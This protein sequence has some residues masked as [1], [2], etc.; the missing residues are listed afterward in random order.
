MKSLIIFIPQNFLKEEP[1]CMYGNVVHDA[2]EEVSKFF[3]LGLTESVQSITKAGNDLVP[4]GY[5]YGTEKKREYWEKKLPNWIELYLSPTDTNYDYYLRT[6]MIRNQKLTSLNSH[7]VIILYDEYCL[8]R[9]ELYI[10]RIPMDHFSELRNILYKESK[11]KNQDK[12]KNSSLPR[13]KETIFT[14]FILTILYPTL[15][16][17]KLITIFNP[18]LKYSSL[19]L[20]L[21]ACFQN[22]KWMASTL[23]QSKK[24]TLKTTNYIL[25]IIID[26]FLGHLLLEVLLNFLENSLPSDVLLSYAEKMV[27]TLKDLVNWLMGSPAGLKLNSSFNRVLGK[28]FLY[29]IHLWWTFLVASKPIMD[30]AF[31]VL[32]FFGRLGITFQISI[33]ADLLALVSFHTYCIY[34]YAARL[35]N[36]QTRGLTALFRLFLGKKKNPLRKRVDSCRYKPDQLFVGTL[37]FTILLFLMPTTWVY[38]FVFTVLRLIMIGLGGF[39]TRLKFYLQVIPIY[40]FILWILRT[41]DTTGSI[42]I[43]LLHRQGE[44]PIM[45]KTKTIIAPWSETW[46]RTLPDTI[47]MHTSINWSNI[48]SN[49]FWGQL[50]N[51]RRTGNISFLCVAFLVN[52]KLADRKYNVRHIFEVMTAKVQEINTKNKKEKLKV[53]DQEKNEKFIESNK[54]SK[55][56]KTKKE[57]KITSQDIKEESLKEILEDTENKKAEKR[58]SEGDE[59]TSKKKRKLK[60]RKS[61]IESDTNNTEELN[62]DNTAMEME[63]ENEEEKPNKEPSKR[64]IKKEKFALR[65]AAIKELGKQQNASKALNYVSKWK[66]AKSEWKFNTVIQTWLIHNLLDENYVP[67]DQYA[68]VLEYFENCKGS[69]RKLL[70]DKAMA[71]IKKLE[72]CVEKE[73]EDEEI[74]ETTEYKRARELLQALPT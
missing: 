15:Y 29:H 50:L 40:A 53:T 56:N 5:F 8:T 43:E 60:N 44:G 2:K 45:L 1:G 35:F 66:H 20:H 7:S 25:A 13:I 30:L 42:G 21:I 59:S 72:D 32:L 3:I 41:V 16:L 63:D 65:E 6:V 11:R 73:D 28:F 18:V 9:T 14:A 67:D 74:I 61:M 10:D 47:T 37:L 22:A 38:Y 70:L 24:F 55:K 46:K 33:M 57:N 17:H 71:V 58:Q 49:V 31:V 48:I 23:Y 54:K 36:I 34:V 26:I 19:G 27:E 39:L 52:L 4:L 12:L 51:S 69:A 68:T 62:L 64:Q